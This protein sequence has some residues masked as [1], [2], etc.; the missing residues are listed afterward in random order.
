MVY[1]LWSIVTAGR[2]TKPTGLVNCGLFW[3]MLQRAAR[4][5]GADTRTHEA[6]WGRYAGIFDPETMERVMLE[7]LQEYG[8]EVL[9]RAH[10][11]DVLMGTELSGIEIT[12]KSG[13]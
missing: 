13:R 10:V 1:T 4:Q 6:R 7:M 11:S 3:E 12:V 2:L 5:G 8:V 9:L